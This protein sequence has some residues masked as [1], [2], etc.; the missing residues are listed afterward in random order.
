MIDTSTL[1]WEDRRTVETREVENVLLQAGFER[2]DAYRYNAASIRVRVIDPKFAGLSREQRDDLVEPQ[3]SKL[4]EHT[5]ADIIS[6]FTFAPSELDPAAGLTR[7]R[8][9]NLEFEDWT[10][11]A[12]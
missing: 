9:L 11:S 1:P 5:Q 7:Q 2:A 3:L 10:P 12:L 4:P 6:L 8:L